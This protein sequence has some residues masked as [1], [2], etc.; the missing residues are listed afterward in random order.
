MK[1]T[2]KFEN[3]TFSGVTNDYQLVFLPPGTHVVEPA[4]W[5]I[6]A[7]GVGL[8]NLGSSI[9]KVK[10]KGFRWE[11]DGNMDL[12]MGK[13]QSSSN[14]IVDKELE[15]TTDHTIILSLQWKKYFKLDSNLVLMD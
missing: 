10:T 3:L 8:L 4:K 2:E 5:H 13:F 15:I 14:E 6:T 11:I 7:E 12:G 1:L 9:N